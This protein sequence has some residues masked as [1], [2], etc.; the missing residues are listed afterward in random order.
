MARLNIAI[1][2]AAKDRA[3]GAISG[4]TGALNSL[5]RS[6]S[7]LLASGFGGI[8]KLGGAVLKGVAGGVVAVATA[9]GLAAKSGFEMNATLET[10][11]LQFTTLMGNADAAEEHVKSL[12]DFAKRTPFETGPIIEASRMMRTFGGE[13]LDT[14]DNLMLIGDAAAATSAPINDLGFWTG[15]LYSQLQA[16][17]P[18]G[19]AAMRLQELAVLSPQ[20]RSQ[21]EELQKA[22]ASADEVFNVFQEDLGRFNG[23]MEAQAGTWEGLKSTITDALQI[24]AATA[25]KPFF[26][27]AK[28]G[29][30]AVVEFLES[31]AFTSGVDFIA[32]KFD[33]L[34]IVAGLFIDHIQSGMPFLTSFRVL[35]TQL[36][37]VF[38][39]AGP[40]ARALGTAVEGF[41]VRVQTLLGPVFDWVLANVE[42][43]DVLTSLGI[44]V[45]GVVLPALGSLVAAV[46]PVILGFGALVAGV[47]LVRTAWENNWGGIQE[48]TQAVI[49]FIVPL[50]ND[51]IAFVKNFWAENNEEILTKAGDIWEGVKTTVSGALD[52][53]WNSV[54]LP[55]VTGI[56]NFWNEHGEDI[57]NRAITTWGLIKSVIQTQLNF[58]WNGII[59][60]IVTAIQSFWNQHG[61]DIK[62]ATKSAWDFIWQTILGVWNLIDLGLQAFIDLFSGDWEAFGTTLNELWTSAWDLIFG[63]IKGL[64]D[65]V[66][67]WFESFWESTKAWFE[68]IDWG[69]LGQKVIDGIVAA[70]GAGVGAVS[71][72]VQ[73]VFDSAAGVFGG[74]GGAS[75]SS[76]GGSGLGSSAASFGGGGRGS[77]GGATFGGGAALAGGGGGNI[78]INIDARG[79][80]PGAEQAIQR[81]V[82]KGLRAAGA[83]ADERKRVNG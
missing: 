57:K 22:G 3:S 16:G 62:T 46:A 21:M 14:K 12:F 64:W 2:I 11:Q 23:A 31:P 9:F 48:K 5:K 72:A 35:I 63:L 25:F 26:E 61:E 79:A 8:D 47:A 40:Q 39:L 45:R 50:I 59:L 76:G 32:D 33:K 49:D 70:I 56:Q 78:I 66:K 51:G 65:T 13:T 34:G 55:I 20:A 41:L 43:S 18:F 30:G 60:P 27:M 74:G 7:S 42:L 69:L 54:I 6:G 83:R 44:A 81:A 19:E 37:L 71:S 24:T 4:V 67:P 52:F 68:T 73:S 77:R 1:E 58:I 75:S 82:S 10:T 15:R 29:L 80:Y 17:K 53:L 28:S 36:G 38:G